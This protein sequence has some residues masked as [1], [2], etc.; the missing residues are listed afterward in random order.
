M[1]IT[2]L[3]IRRKEFKRSVRGYSDEDVDLFL[4]AVADEFERLF[5]GNMELQDRLHALEEQVGGQARIR[6]ALEKTLVA[7]QVQSEEMRSNAEREGESI[8]R[9]AETKAKGV[10]SE[11]YSQTQR[12]QQTLIQ[13]KLL[14]EDFRFKFRSLL[15][16]HLK[17]LNEG[18]IVLVGVD[19][20]AIATEPSPVEEAAPEMPEVAMAVGTPQ[21]DLR[22]HD[23]APTLETEETAALVVA[24]VDAQAAAGAGAADLD[25]STE[26][27]TVETSQLA[28]E[29]SAGKGAEEKGTEEESAGPGVFFGRQLDDPDDPFPGS[30]VTEPAKARDFEW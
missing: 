2:P 3:D 15:E 27:V 20:G 16:G 13:L 23:D 14:E 26:E 10:V 4:D 21:S 28:K 5:Q 1:K 6:E 7:A 17:M 18:S 9:D 24:A 29:T 22:L 25:E 30:D 11:L 12:V 8:L 19:P